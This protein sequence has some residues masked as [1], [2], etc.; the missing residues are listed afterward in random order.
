MLRV[1]MFSTADKVAG[2]GVGSVYVELLRLLRTQ[3]NDELK[4]EV[5][6]YGRADISHYHTVNPQYYLSTFMPNRGRKIGFVHFLPETLEGSLKLPR[7]FKGIFY[8]YVIAFYKRMD[9]LVVVNPSFKEKLMAYG[10]AADKITYIPNFVSK[11]TF[12][13]V[14]DKKRADLRDAY[15]YPHKFTVLGSGQVQVRKGVPDFIELAKRNPDMQ[16]IW[17]GGF[18]F[19]RITDG[20][21]ELK[22]V[23]DD[24]PAN[25]S[26][27]GIVDRNRLV[28][29]YNMADVFLLPS[30]NELFPMSVLEA[31]SAHTPVLVRNLDLYDSILLGDYLGADDVDEMDRD[32]H[33]LRDDPAELQDLQN[34]AKDA[35]DYYS[36]DRLVKIWVKFYQ[37]QAHLRKRG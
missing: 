2:Q 13:P 32:L 28:D 12:Y 6:K 15:H 25:L 8:R 5:N 3:A 22:K 16:F 26:F 20:Y 37:D 34:K 33:K 9:Q 27:P 35:A 18:S 21:A 11:S 17:T 1:T 14:T 29:Y 10:I 7:L 31:F 24:S 19:G 30:Y 4:I 36:E 23:V